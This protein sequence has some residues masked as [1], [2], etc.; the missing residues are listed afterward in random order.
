MT[1]KSVPKILARRITINGKGKKAEGVSSISFK[2]V[3]LS[4]GETYVDPI[5][6]WSYGRTTG[7]LLPGDRMA[8]LNGMAFTVRER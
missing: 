2:T 4:D 3:V 1:T 8:V 7:E 6:E 5:V